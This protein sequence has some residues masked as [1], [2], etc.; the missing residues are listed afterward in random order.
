MGQE[1]DRRGVLRAASAAVVGVGEALRPLRQQGVLLVGSGG[2]AHNRRRLDFVR[3]HAPVASWAQEFDSWVAERIV[4]R[5]LAGLMD[6]T[7]APHAQLAHPT[8]A[9][10]LPIFF[11][12]G[13]ALAE[14]RTTPVFEGF[15]HSTL[16]MRSFA[17]RT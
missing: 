14:D 2:V 9:H 8:V 17:L 10:W 12:L 6:W 7:R 15:H 1:L 11:V 4:S 16:S 3:K 13:A 5:D